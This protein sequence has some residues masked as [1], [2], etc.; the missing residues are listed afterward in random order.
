MYIS[1][2]MYVIHLDSSV[3]ATE[4]ALH[5]ED[6][7]QTLAFEDAWPHWILTASARALRVQVLSLSESGGL[8]GLG[9]YG[10]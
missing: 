9:S 10:G 3:F 2:S 5:I 7:L 1:L 4:P 8:W 6:A